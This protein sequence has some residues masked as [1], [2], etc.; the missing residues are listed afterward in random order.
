MLWGKLLLTCAGNS[1]KGL[2]SGLAS[3]LYGIAFYRNDTAG[4]ARQAART[5]VVPGQEGFEP[6]TKPSTDSQRPTIR[7]YR[8]FVRADVYG[9]AVYPNRSAL[10]CDQKDTSFA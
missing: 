6:V 7:Q 5:T 9:F 10:I 8:F 2:D 1:G 3:V 4:M